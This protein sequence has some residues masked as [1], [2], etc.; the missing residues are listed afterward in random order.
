MTEIEAL[1]EYVMDYAADLAASPGGY[2]PQLADLD[3]AIQS[4]RVELD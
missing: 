1:N 2:Q 4:L 3:A